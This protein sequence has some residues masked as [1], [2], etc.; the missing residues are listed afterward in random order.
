MKIY[1][2]N[3]HL[4]AFQLYKGSNIDQNLHDNLNFLWE[5]GDAVVKET[6][7][8]D[9]QLSQRLDVHQQPESR[10]VD[11]LKDTEVIDDNY[12]VSFAG[13]VS[14]PQNQN[15]LIKGFAHPLRISDSYSLWLNLRRPEQEN[16]Q[17]TEDVEI[18]FFRVFNPNNC[19]NFKAK[20]HPFFLGQTLLITGWLIKPKD[21]NIVRQMTDWLTV[22]RD[23]KRIREIADECLNQFYVNQNVPDF[24]RQGKLFGSVI[25]EYGLINNLENYQHVLIWL[26]EDVETDHKFGE[27]CHELED[28][29][30]YRTKIVKAYQDSREIYKQ[31]DIFY[32]QIEI[33]IDE[34]PEKQPNQPATQKYLQE[35]QK[36]L[37]SF[38]Q[39]AFKYAR[40]LRDLEEHANTIAIH[41]V[42]YN[43]ILK[44]IQAILT[45]EDLSFIAYFTENQAANFQRQIEADLRY[46]NNGSQLLDQ[47]INSIRGIVEIEQTERDRSLERTI[48]RL[49]IGF[50]GGAIISGVITQHIDKINHPVTFSLNKPPHPF[51]A[52]LL[53]SII[54]TLFFIGLGFLI[55]K[56]K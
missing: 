17:P 9:L 42:N 11:L 31:L 54:A 46:F 38:P 33:E 3:V 39:L 14:Y 44:N 36:K 41:I 15:I 50:G 52:S 34:I 21:N 23:R 7:K 16:N 45:N 4:F 47:A 10:R 55:T 40:L 24:Y 25:F 28:L 19:L 26:F 56:R 43:Q 5:S 30:F 35:L 37:K 53:L 6:L 48:G 18:D 29:F 32:R 22:A 1:A 8:Q 49:G 27:V 20:Q 13:L 51:Y 2:P 12:A